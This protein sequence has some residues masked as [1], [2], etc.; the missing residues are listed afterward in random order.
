MAP[1]DADTIAAFRRGDDHAVRAMYAGYGR[2]VF[3]VA[4]RVLGDRSL[5]DEATQ[6]TFVQAWRAASSFDVDRDP[7]PWLATI[8]R[9]VAIDIQRR[10]QRRPATPLDDAPSGDSSMVTA[11]PSAEQLWETWEVRAAI[12]SLVPDERVVVQ[13][14]HLEGFT[15]QEIADRLGIAVGTVKSRSFRAHRTLAT[16][17]RHLR[18]PSDDP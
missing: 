9:R 5:A 10:E 4:H 11:A 8:A 12:E 17:L 16:R 7:A 3:A 13:L 6:Q 14:Q 18:E 15:H 2:L 1:V